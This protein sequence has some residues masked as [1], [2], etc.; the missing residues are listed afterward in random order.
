MLR[1]IFTKHNAPRW[2]ILFIDL[3]ISFSSLIIAYYLRFNFY[4]PGKFVD[5][6]EFNS[7]YWVIPL[8]LSVRL[9][10]FLISKSYTGIIRYTGT[11]DAGKI[12]IV[13]LSGTLVLVISNLISYRINQSYLIPFS[14]IGIDFLANIFIMTFSRLLVKNLYAEYIGR[15]NE[16]GKDNVLILGINDMALITKKALTNDP[17]SKYKIVAFIDHTGVH[18]GQKLDGISVFD[19]GMFEILLEKLE[20]TSVIFSEKNLPAHIKEQVVEQCLNR[21]I[22]VLTLP[23]VTTWINGEFSVKQIRKVKIDDLLEETLLSW[24]MHK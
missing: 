5:Y 3:V 20:I 24:M 10:S 7:L 12:F 19:I 18:K 11:K 23:D 22:K 17:N 16:E 21:S 6:K 14:V 4:L 15:L 13:I 8:V 9:M 2:I 1:Y